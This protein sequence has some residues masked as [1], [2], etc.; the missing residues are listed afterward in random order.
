MPVIAVIGKGRDCLPDV[1]DLAYQVGL[2]VGLIPEQVCVVTGGL[3][4]VM[5]HAALGASHGHAFVLSLVPHGRID[6]A[7]DWAN[8]QLRTGLTE[9]QRNAMMGAVAD[10]AIMLPGSH[11]T[12]QEATVMLDAGVPLVA[13]GPHAGY[14]T[15]QLLGEL[16]WRPGPFEAVHALAALMNLP[17]PLLSSQTGPRSL[18]GSVAAR[19]GSQG[20]GVRPADPGAV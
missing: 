4:G 20:V 18:L 3:G 11:G 14:R 13:C 6:D 2:H 17:G 8:L 7:H 16:E 9:P 12:V 1:A 10:G 19:Q 15:A 5:E